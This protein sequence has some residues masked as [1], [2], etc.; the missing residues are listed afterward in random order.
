MDRSQLQ[1]TSAAEAEVVFATA[2]QDVHDRMAPPLQQGRETSV[3]KEKETNQNHIT[4]RLR[5]PLLRPGFCSILSFSRFPGSLQ[6]LVAK[7]AG[8]DKMKTKKGTE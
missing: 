7:M 4:S 1:L 2:V 6:G 5:S 8:D 3:K